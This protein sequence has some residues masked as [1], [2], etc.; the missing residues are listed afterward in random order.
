MSTAELKKANVVSLHD[1]RNAKVAERTEK[2]QAQLE[3]RSKITHSAV[4]SGMLGTLQGHGID[5]RSLKGLGAVSKALEDVIK[6]HLSK[7]GDIVIP[8]DE[9]PNNI[10]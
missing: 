10:A 4:I 8:E 1:F 6:E 5:P 2:A 9:S 3:A 7:G